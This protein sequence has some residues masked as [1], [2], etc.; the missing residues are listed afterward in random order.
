MFK[1]VILGTSVLIA[2]IAAFFS[3][4]GLGKMFAGAFLPVVIMASVLEFSKL[5]TISFLSRY[6]KNLTTLLKSYYVVASTILVMITS[7]GIYGFLTAAY[8]TTSTEL[9]ILNQEIGIIDLKKERLQE[10]LDLAVQEREQLN[11]NIS[12]LS[13][14]LANNVIQYR[15]QATGQLITTTSSAT[16]TALEG[17]LATN[18]NRQNQIS[19]D[20]ESLADSISSLD[21][22]ALDMQANSE[23]AGEVGPLLFLSELT[24]MPMNRI[25]N[26]FT[27][28]IVLVFD[29]LAITLLIG[30]HKLQNNDLIFKEQNYKIYEE[31]DVEPILEENVTSVSESIDNPIETTLDLNAH[32]F[33]VEKTSSAEYGGLARMLRR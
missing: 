14:G 15:D 27:I 20:I 29:P 32:G 2:T 19:N 30:Y 3:V 11:S 6:W 33:T 8:Q 21:I 17:Q 24:G 13:R 28:L 10:Q 12:E 1:F 5:V 16:R 7:L 4:S 26:I 18:R 9:S 31:P 22:Q 23:I 25:V